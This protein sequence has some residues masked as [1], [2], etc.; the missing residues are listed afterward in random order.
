[1]TLN[2][3]PAI[4]AVWIAWWLLPLLSMFVIGRLMPTGAPVLQEGRIP[5]LFV[6]ACGG[7][8]MLL[9]L[10]LVPLL[11]VH[12]RSL[13]SA[14]TLVVGWSAI[15]GAWTG[16]AIVELIYRPPSSAVGEPVEFAPNGVNRGVLMLRPTSGEATSARF[17]IPPIDSL[18]AYT[19]AGNKPVKGRVYKGGRNLWFARL[20]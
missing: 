18:D 6:V 1:L 14:L 4:K 19:R 8:W 17:R 7:C 3:S 12:G 11:G 5:N 9:G 16:P 13:A 10:G 20:D 2:C 15:A